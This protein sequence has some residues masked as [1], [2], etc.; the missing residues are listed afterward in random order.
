MAFIL[1]WVAFILIWV[2]FIL[3]WVAFILM[4]VAS[5][6]IWVT[7]VLIVGVNHT[8]QNTDFNLEIHKELDGVLLTKLISD[9]FL[10][11]YIQISSYG[12]QR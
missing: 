3:I 10:P 4:K 5:I 1:I 8:D 6:L 7:F 11:Y 9:F 12:L 2:A